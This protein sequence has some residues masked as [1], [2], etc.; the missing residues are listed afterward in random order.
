MRAA[1]VHLFGR[2]G[3]NEGDGEVHRGGVCCMHGEGAHQMRRDELRV[4]CFAGIMYICGGGLYV[5][6]EIAVA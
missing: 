4:K 1:I 3:S 5:T 6:C 2:N